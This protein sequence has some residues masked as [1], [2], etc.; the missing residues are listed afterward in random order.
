MLFFDDLP[1][2]IE[3]AAAQGTT[4]VL[5]GK[6]GLTWPAFTA[7]MRGWRDCIKKIEAAAAPAEKHPVQN[8][9][10]E[11]WP[12]EEGRQG[13]GEAGAQPLQPEA[14]AADAGLG[15]KASN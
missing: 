5:L 9:P 11:R 12:Q 1:E 4:G 3:A 8:G 13:E 15:G 2:N 6:L 10:A 14:C 7:G